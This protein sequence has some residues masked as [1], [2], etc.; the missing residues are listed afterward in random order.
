ML[1]IAVVGYILIYTGQGAYYD[2]DGSDYG[3]FEECWHC[4]HCSRLWGV[5]RLTNAH[6]RKGQKC[7]VDEELAKQESLKNK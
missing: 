3:D 4:C 6:V 1:I 7:N 2:G 5:C